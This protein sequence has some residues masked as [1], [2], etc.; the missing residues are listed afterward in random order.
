MSKPEAYL[1]SHSVP[2]AN[3]LRIV[4]TREERKILI[5][6][7]IYSKLYIFFIEP[8]K[9][10]MQASKLA[11][12]P[13]IESLFNKFSLKNSNNAIDRVLSSVTPQFIE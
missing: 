8:L 12:V 3:K 7:V 10:I 1:G 2:A 4:S 5:I 9:R 6:R 11:A 13:K